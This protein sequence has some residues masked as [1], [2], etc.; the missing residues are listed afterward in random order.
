M[1]NWA[2]YLAGPTLPGSVDDK[3]FGT[4]V[5]THRNRRAFLAGCV[6]QLEAYL[7]WSHDPRPWTTA[8]GRAS[9]RASGS[10][11]G[12]GARVRS[13]PHLDRVAPQALGLWWLIN[14]PLS[15]YDDSY[16]L[17]PDLEDEA[18]DPDRVSS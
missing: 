2:A 5:I 4:V 7:V 8:D 9:G 12:G 16:E 6:R 11:T 18:E 14:R 15:K 3:G 13:S 10:D 1:D 17:L